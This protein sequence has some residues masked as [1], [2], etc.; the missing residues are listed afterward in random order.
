MA[1]QKTLKLT[2]NFGTET[3]IPNVYIKVSE[4]LFCKNGSFGTIQFKKTKEDH[5]CSSC[6]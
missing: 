1:L 6:R 3:E 5:W 2:N 4:V